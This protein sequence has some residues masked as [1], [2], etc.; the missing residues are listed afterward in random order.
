M[1]RSGALLIGRRRCLRQGERA[2]GNVSVGLG[3]R[4]LGRCAR[5]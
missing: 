2:G 5:L 1:T 4:H 3:A